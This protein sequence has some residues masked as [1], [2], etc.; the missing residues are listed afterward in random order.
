MFLQSTYQ[1]LQ[2]SSRNNLSLLSDCNLT[3]QLL[4]AFIF[5]TK[6]P[7][8]NMSFNLAKISFEIR[9]LAP[10]S[11]LF[12]CEHILGW[13]RVR[14]SKFSLSSA[15]EV[16]SSLLLKNRSKLALSF[17]VSL[18]IILWQTRPIWVP[19]INCR[20]WSMGIAIGIEKE[21]CPVN[22]WTFVGSNKL[23]LLNEL[24]FNFATKNERSHLQ[25]K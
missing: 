3:A 4:I 24:P 7:D 15:A 21:F 25:K 5:A 17:D 2:C 20:N 8:C 18:Q 19:C 13:I 11:A 22:V 16:I 12:I 10:L 1:I 14:W 9:T 6:I 23:L